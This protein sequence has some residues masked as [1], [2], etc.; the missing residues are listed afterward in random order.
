MTVQ[1]SC[2]YCDGP[3]SGSERRIEKCLACGK[4]Y[5][6]RHGQAFRLNGVHKSRAS[7]E[8]RTAQEHNALMRAFHQRALEHFKECAHAFPLIQ[9]SCADDKCSCAFCR[10][11]KGKIIP[12]AQA[13]LAMIPPFAECTSETG[14]CRCTFI[15]IARD[16]AAQLGLVPVSTTG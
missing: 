12:T 3:I 8:E 2:P 7:A 14:K 5:S 11:Q 1:L 10:E 13:T 15:A 4:R 6:I 9:I 16:Y